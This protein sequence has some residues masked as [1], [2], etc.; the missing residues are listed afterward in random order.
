MPDLVTE[1][2]DSRL[3]QLLPHALEVA[4]VLVLF[5]AVGAGCGWLWFQVWEEPVGFVYQGAW[6][7]DEE[8]LRNVFGGTAWY[9]AIAAGGGLVTGAV[10]TLLGR[11]MP[12]VTM[13]A[14]LA[15][16]ALAAWLMYAV[17]VQLSPADPEVLARTAEDGAELSGRLSLEDGRSAYL[18]WPFGALIALM[19]LNFLLSSREQIQAREHHDPQWLTRNHPG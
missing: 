8:G 18:A 9:V 6:Y 2:R 16:S 14:V 19:V 7:P 10:A 1:E 11:R 13:G 5:A 12:L 4:A 15:G 17:G 3:R